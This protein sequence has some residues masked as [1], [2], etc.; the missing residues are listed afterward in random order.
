MQ[1]GAIRV[2]DAE[3]IEASIF[4]V[5]AS[6]VRREQ[7]AALR[8]RTFGTVP[9]ACCE[10]VFLSQ[11]YSRATLLNGPFQ[12]AVATIIR[13]HAVDYSLK[14]APS[15]SASGGS[16]SDVHL[17]SSLTFEH[18]MRGCDHYDSRVMSLKKPNNGGIDLGQVARISA[19]SHEW[20]LLPEDRYETWL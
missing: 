12:Q 15:N 11:L 19:E 4:T 6:T 14:H 9:A 5:Q 1:V 17:T 18:N 2:S 20:S 7:R 13:S 10:E 3:R 8:G 16:G